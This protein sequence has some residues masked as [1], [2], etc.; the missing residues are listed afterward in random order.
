MRERLSAR[1]GKRTA[2]N[3][4]IGTFHAI[5]L[6]LLDKRPILSETEALQAMREVLKKVGSGM[7]AVEALHAVSQIKCGG[8][9]AA[10]DAGVMDAYGALCRA[11]GVRDLDDLLLDALA[12]PG[13]PG[14]Q[15]RY[16]LVDEYQDVNAIQ[17]RLIRHWSADGGHLFVI[18]DP[19]QSIYGFRGA[20]AGCFDALKA[21]FP[22]FRTI[23]LRTNYRSTP[24]II[25]AA[26]AVIRHNPGGMRTLEAQKP[27]GASVR[28][29]TADTPFSEGVY[30]AKEIGR[31]TGGVDMLSAQS[32]HANQ[33]EARSFSEI[34]VL[35]RT[36]RQ[37]E[38]IESC[39]SHDGIPCVISG[40]GSYLGDE[41]VS[42]AL[43]FF[44]A[45]L[46][47]RSPLTAKVA[48]DGTENA[49]DAGYDPFPAETF[50]AYEPLLK[51]EPPKTLL[52]RWSAEHGSNPAFESLL[53]AAAFFKTMADFLNT[54]TLGEEADLR[55]M[56][57]KGDASGAVRLATLHGAKG[58][59]FPVV[60]LAGVTAGVLPL[61][62]AD[63]CADLA[64]E[65]R[66][67]YVGM[68]RARESLILTACEPLSAFIQEL[69][70]AVEKSTALSRHRASAGK[71][72]SLF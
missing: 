8:D 34:A 71:Q 11:R 32:L 43:S 20:D 44:R 21:D 39:L 9:P 56:S 69:P 36:H 1:L 7:D 4:H 59:E 61:E 42:R 14:K 64:E 19:D 62:R 51:S 54:L 33:L 3:L 5:C 46:K 52:S 72:L 2:Q 57:G 30:I 16:L 55:R 31:L 67:F 6:R 26:L 63:G 49:P 25:S 22:D 29:V 27:S 68:T 18:G 23:R 40:R 41:T 38:Q 70:K 53:S 65:R 58:L 66:L 47:R 35:A 28:L 17:R 45:L 37:L 24:A 12:L 48:L 60:F 13:R 15:F 10:L 50:D